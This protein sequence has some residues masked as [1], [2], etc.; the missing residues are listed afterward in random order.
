MYVKLFVVHFTVIGAYA[1]LLH[2]RREPRD[3]FSFALMLA[4][5]IA[6]IALFLSP[7]ITLLIQIMI[8]RD[9]RKT[10]NHSNGILIGWMGR[11][12]DTDRH[13]AGVTWLRSSRQSWFG[14][15]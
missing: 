3:I 12:E 4:C 8:G 1:H 11:D 14:A 13:K 6:G 7:F 5:P 10:L 9:D 2:L 15:S